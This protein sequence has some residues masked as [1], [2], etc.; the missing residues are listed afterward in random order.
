MV[1]GTEY[2]ERSDTGTSIVSNVVD[3]VER[4]TRYQNTSVLPE[5]HVRPLRTRILK[6]QKG[7][8]SVE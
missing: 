1:Q 8:K 4:F 7:K 2:V 3:A 6:N 5:H